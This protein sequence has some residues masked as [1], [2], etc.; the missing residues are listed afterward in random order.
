VVPLRAP[1]GRARPL[2]ARPTNR[3][4]TPGDGIGD[5]DV[6]KQQKTKKRERKLLASCEHRSD[7]R[8][9]E[10][11]VRRM[12]DVQD[13]LCDLLAEF[14]AFGHFSEMEDAAWC[15]RL[16]QTVK[17]KYDAFATTGVWP[18]ER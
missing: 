15:L 9:A 5:G 17:K 6:S 8:T 2:R 7:R 1:R 13:D 11:L 4:S 10:F 18:E 3:N 14:R 12:T 16:L